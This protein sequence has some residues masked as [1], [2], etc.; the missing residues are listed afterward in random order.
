MT[1]RKV[2]SVSGLKFAVLLLG[3]AYGDSAGDEYWQGWFGEPELG[4]ESFVNLLATHTGAE[5]SFRSC[6]KQ[7]RRMIC[8]LGDRLF[9][10]QPSYAILRGVVG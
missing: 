3:S 8:D 6:R 4:I 1:L 2:H 10:K 9:S 5:N 7:R